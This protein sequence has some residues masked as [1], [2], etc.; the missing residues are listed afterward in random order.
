MSKCVLLFFYVVYMKEWE[1]KHMFL[2]HVH[3][4]GNVAFVFSQGL[5]ILLSDHCLRCL[6]AP[7]LMHPHKNDPVYPWHT[8]FSRFGF[9]AVASCSCSCSPLPLP[10]SLS[11][12][13]Y[14]SDDWKTCKHIPSGALI[15]GADLSHYGFSVHQGTLQRNNESLSF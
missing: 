15:S 2:L 14:H 13:G 9:S 5:Y 8:L 6:C 3:W 12:R 4:S 10:P 11:H 1:K 7:L